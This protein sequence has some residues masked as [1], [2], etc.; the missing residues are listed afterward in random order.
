[1][2]ASPARPARPPGPPFRAAL[3]KRRRFATARPFPDKNASFSEQARAKTAFIPSGQTASGERRGPH[4]GKRPRS[5]AGPPGA[6]R[7]GAARSIGEAKGGEG[8]R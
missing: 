1:M 5:K 3:G 7:G 6:E 8:R 2:A 4:L